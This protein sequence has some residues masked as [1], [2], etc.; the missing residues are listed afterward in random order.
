MKPKKK[1]S[2]CIKFQ[3]I[4]LFAIRSNNGL[5]NAELYLVSNID[6]GLYIHMSIK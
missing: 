1:M 6:I 4:K 5:I 3:S 2:G